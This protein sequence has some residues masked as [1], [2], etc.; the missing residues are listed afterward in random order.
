MGKVMMCVA[1]VFGLALGGCQTDGAPTTTAQAQAPV[2]EPPPPRRNLKPVEAMGEARDRVTSALKDPESARFTEV[3]YKPAQPNA[4]G[5]PTD[6]VCGMVNAKN[7]F[8]GYTG[9]KPFVYFVDRKQVTMS[10]GAGV[11]RELGLTIYKNFCAGGF[12]G[13]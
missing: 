8:G 13:R 12:G 1:L 9:A 2:A 6:V 10:D 3:T 11:D 4:R 5:E 7:S